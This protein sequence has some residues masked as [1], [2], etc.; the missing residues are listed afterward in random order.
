M[1]SLTT[2]RLL[3]TA[4]RPYRT[5]LAAGITM[6]LVSTGAMMVLP[7]MVKHMF[8]AGLHAGDEAVLGNTAFG[9]V[10]LTFVM[11]GGVLVRSQLIQL[12]STRVAC[13]VRQSLLAKL[14]ELDVGWFEQRQSGQLMSRLTDD[15]ASLRDFVNIA[16]PM[17]IRGTLLAVVSLAMLLVTSVKLTGV[18]VAVIVPAVAASIILGRRV[19]VLNRTQQD[20][21]AKFAGLLGDV[22]GQAAL[23]RV[24]GREAQAQA[25]GRARLNAIVAGSSR[26]LLAISGVVAANVVLGF[27]G[28]AGVIWLG[29][30]DVIHGT[31]TV[32]GMLAF[33][34][35]L[36]FLADA[37]SNLSGFWP[38]WQGTL[39]A[40][41][42]VV[43]ILN[44]HSALKVP[45]TP[46]PLPKAKNGRAL[47][48][49]KI[50]YAYPARPDVP[51]LQ[52]V[53]LHI[54]AGANVAIVGPSGA[55][56]S[57]LLRLFL[58]LDDP[59]GGSVDVDGTDVRTATLTEVRAQF[60]L[61]AQDAPLLGGT[62]AE[63][64][65]FGVENADEKALWKA[66]ETASA[67]AFVKALPEGLNT[68]VGERGVQLSGGQRQRLALARAVLR[69]AP[70]LLL[71]EAT[72]HL[73]AE[74]EATVQAAL[75]KAGQGRTVVS[76]AHRLSTVMG[77]DQIIVM[78]HGQVEATG[79]HAHLLKH[80][81]TYAALVALQLKG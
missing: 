43:G 44:E 14:L 55:G 18:L 70:V 34:M 40:L 75:A 77:A 41:D 22:V 45:A 35:Y 21:L 56:K 50:T 68:L 63:N 32:G 4:V 36:G 42:R 6:L 49:K 15:V 67:A 39:G 52:G 24:F 74:S 30:L 51:V 26:Q 80:N 23:W 69:K 54:P 31:L 9:I 53:S 62:V 33:L 13:D 71:D 7:Q 76:I 57:T 38:A 47:A 8:D 79:T 73:D 60:G 20:L 16:I 25:Q 11:A 28:L 37:A 1:E 12:T 65:M 10:A 19:R 64:L 17:G 61:V 2:G 81:P 29:G 72:S 5:R 66:L 78:N 3:R 46:T 58:R 48:L 59:Q 27:T